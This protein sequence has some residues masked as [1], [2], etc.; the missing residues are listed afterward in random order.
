MEKYSHHVQGA[1]TWDVV[2]QALSES[3]LFSF[4]TFSAVPY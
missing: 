1:V 3:A 2:S 4:H